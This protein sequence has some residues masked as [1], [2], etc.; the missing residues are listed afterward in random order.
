MEKKSSLFDRKVCC[1]PNH[2]Q[3]HDNQKEVI[4]IIKKL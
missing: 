4:E 2:R 3:H 1:V